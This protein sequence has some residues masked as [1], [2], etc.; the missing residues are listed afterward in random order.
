MIDVVTSTVPSQANIWRCLIGYGLP[1]GQATEICGRDDVGLRA[2]FAA[3]HSPSSHDSAVRIQIVDPAESVLSAR[4]ELANLVHRL[5]RLSD[6]QRQSL[7]A[8][9]VA[10][11]S[12]DELVDEL[13]V[14]DR[15]LTTA[16]GLLALGT[17]SSDAREAAVAALA[18]L[19]ELPTP[20][21]VTSP[22]I[23]RRARVLAV[24]ALGL[25]LVG[26]QAALASVRE[27]TPIE[28]AA[29]TVAAEQTTTTITS[30][31]DPPTAPA[32]YTEPDREVEV[33]VTD[34]NT[35]IRQEPWTRE[36][37]WE[38]RPF[39]ADVE[40][41]RVDLNTVTIE[42]SGTRLIVSL[43]DGTLLPP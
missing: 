12:L 3:T 31:V 1:V 32:R 23:N 17:S 36:V 42:Y 19:V 24:A 10:G 38:S 33:A 22:K 30:T 39:L 11:L 13:G 5:S 6:P 43:T 2:A 9:H 8:H 15:D 34:D 20:T 21:S 26:G 16:E 35:I 27:R 29:L 7:L 37:I 14:D 28:S 41:I 18:P 40:I 4:G 25:A